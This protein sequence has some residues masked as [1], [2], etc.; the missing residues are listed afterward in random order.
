MDLKTTTLK[1][2]VEQNNI[3]KIDILKMDIEGSE[4]QVLEHA[5]ESGTLE[6]VDKMVLELH[7]NPKRGRTFDKI[8]KYLYDDFS[9]IVYN[10]HNKVLI[11]R[12]L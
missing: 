2:I 10:K 4:Y 5:Y 11:A 8:F 12:K 9:H 1:E 6:V 3:E 7:V